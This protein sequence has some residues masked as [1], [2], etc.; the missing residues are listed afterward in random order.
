MSWI[1]D[2]VQA[3]C[4]K[5]KLINP[6]PCG[7]QWAAQDFDTKKWVDVPSEHVEKP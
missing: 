5:N 3:F 7:S 2:H 6:T 4:A 1:P